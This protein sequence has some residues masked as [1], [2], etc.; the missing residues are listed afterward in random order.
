MELRLTPL[1]AFSDNYIWLLSSGSVAAA[2]DPGDA[3]PVR[4]A[5]AERRLRLAAVLITHHH[6]DHMGGACALAAEHGCPVYGPAAE[7]IDAVNVP[8]AEGA[9]LEVAALGARLRV[10]DIPGHTAGHIAYEGHGIIFCGDTLFSAG[11]GRLFEGTAGQMC[12]SLVKITAL[13]DDT[14]VCCGHEYTL[15]NLKFAGQVEPDNRDVRD[16]LEEC[17]ARRGRGEPTLP[18]TLGRERR[19]NPF[20]RC[21]VA[22]VRE[23]A[24]ERLGREPADAVEVFATLRAWKDGFS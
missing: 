12:A 16:Y 2:I 22:A 4:A 11:C 6:P 24:R 20:L 3:E 8:L 14:R 10:L 19:V 13:P 9:T 15:G 7:P 18:S 1:P 23:A 17:A 5:L 21:H